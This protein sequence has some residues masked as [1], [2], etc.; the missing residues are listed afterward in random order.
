MPSLPPSAARGHGRRTCD[1]CPDPFLFAA[2]TAPDPCCC[3]CCCASCR[4]RNV[5]FRPGRVDHFGNAE[6]DDDSADDSPYQRGQ[7]ARFWLPSSLLPADS[8]VSAAM[9]EWANRSAV[10]GVSVRGGPRL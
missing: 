10:G 9:P 2:G 4:H 5:E 3:C 8:E 6:A 7:R 1:C